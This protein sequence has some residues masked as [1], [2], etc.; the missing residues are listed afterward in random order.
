MKSAIALYLTTVS[1]PDLDADVNNHCLNGTPNTAALISYSAEVT[2]PTC[3]ADI[4]EGADVTTGSSF[5]TDFCRTVATSG[6]A[7]LT[8]GTGWVP[9]KL[10][11][12]VG[13]S[14]ISS[15]PLDPS[16]DAPT[17]APDNTKRVYRYVC[18]AS[19]DTA[20]DPSNVFELNAVL[21]STEFNNKM[22]KDGGDNPNYYEVG[23]STKL[24]GTGTN[25]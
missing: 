12:V 4:A 15:M 13:G 24:L 25:Y 9:V 14:P 8:D 6:A 16:N 21:E 22:T 23:T 3:N 10:S 11:D 1:S 19:S 2:D 20:G 17:T 18:Q 5:A 7:S